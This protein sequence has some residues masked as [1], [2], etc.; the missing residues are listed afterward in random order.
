MIIG[1]N[2]GKKIKNPSIKNKP[3]QTKTFSVYLLIESLSLQLLKTYFFS[4]ICCKVVHFHS[5]R[6][7]HEDKM[8]TCQQVN[9]FHF[10]IYLS[11]GIPRIARVLTLKCTLV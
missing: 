1:L 2:T 11:N 6:Q 8:S 10:F 3:N 9:K 7:Y 4:P 5:T